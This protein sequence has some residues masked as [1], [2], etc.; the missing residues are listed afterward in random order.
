MSAGENLASTSGSSKCNSASE[1]DTPHFTGLYANAEA[2]TCFSRDEIQSF[3][4]SV[5]FP[6]YMQKEERG[7]APLENSDEYSSSSFDYSSLGL[8][9]HHLLSVQDMLLSA[10]AFAD[11]ATLC[12]TLASTAWI[13]T[14]LKAIFFCPLSVSVCAVDHVAST[15]TP[16]FA[17]DACRKRMITSGKSGRFAEAN[18]L[19]LWAIAPEGELL[20]EVT[21]NLLDARPLRF[22]SRSSGRA[23]AMVDVTHIFDAAGKH[24]CV[25]GV[26]SD[27]TPSASS[28]THVAIATAGTTS[29]D[30]KQLERY[31]TDNALL[32]AFLIK[33]GAQLPHSQSPSC[34]GSPAPAAPAAPAPGTPQRNA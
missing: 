7:K 9:E 12:T 15:I 2:R 6:L 26:Q 18:I 19:Q 22:V 20:E 11:E 34:P 32:I 33:T 5:V 13:N 8:H 25:L 23:P 21:A 3:L 14:L 1:D 24:C 10:A 29:P 16:V 4:F 27:A 17:N 31:L 28:P 30:K